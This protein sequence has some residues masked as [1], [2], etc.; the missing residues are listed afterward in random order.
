[1]ITIENTINSAVVYADSID[2]G[3]EGLIRALCASP[4]SNGSKIRIMPDVHA[5][6]GCAVGTTM[7]LIDCVAPGLVGTDIGCGM[8]VCKVSGKRIEFQKLDKVIRELI[9]AGHNIRTK[10]HRFA[11]QT[12]LDDLLCLRHIQKDKALCSIRTE[13]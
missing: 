1:M 2:S 10:A 6:K 13:R 4:I 3:A 5:G 8:T 7:T 9:P 12:E 11:E